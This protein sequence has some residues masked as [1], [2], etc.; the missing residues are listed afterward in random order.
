MNGIGRFDARR[1]RKREQR[2]SRLWSG[3]MASERK[4]NRARPYETILPETLHLVEQPDLRHAALDLAV[5]RVGGRGCPGQPLLP[6]SR[7]C[8]RSDPAFRA[9][10]GDL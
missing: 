10:L 6:D 1:T 9:A 2:R 7:R 5:R 8:G 3:G 4:A